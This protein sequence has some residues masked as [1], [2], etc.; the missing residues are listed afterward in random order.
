MNEV[1]KYGLL[2]GLGIC[3][4]VYVGCA[5]VTLFLIPFAFGEGFRVF[6]ET[7]DLRDIVTGRAESPWVLQVYCVLRALQRWSGAAVVA[8]TVAFAV[9]AAT[10]K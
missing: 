3:G 2:L 7:K 5:A 6:A 9:W 10:A 4:L 8:F 1:T